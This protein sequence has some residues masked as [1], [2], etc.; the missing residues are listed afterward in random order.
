MISWPPFVLWLNTPRGQGR[1]LFVTDRG[2]D[3][4]LEWTIVNEKGEIWSALN[5]EVKVLKNIT[6][7]VGLASD[8]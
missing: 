6:Y 4:D 1:V 7:G 2:P 3:S 5:F 8:R